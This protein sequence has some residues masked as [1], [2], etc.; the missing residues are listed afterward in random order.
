MS[1][2]L[3]AIVIAKNEARNIEACLDSLAFCDQRVVV[4]GV[5]RL[6]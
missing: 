5:D 2:R 1:Q 6:L 4:D 3:S